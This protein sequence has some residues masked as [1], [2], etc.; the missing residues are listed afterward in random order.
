MPLS[1]AALAHNPVGLA[2][3]ILEKFSTWTNVAYR[4]LND[5]GFGK[6]FSNDALIDNL[7]IYYLSNSIT[8]S[9]RLYAESLSSRHH[10][11][12]LDLV[13]TDVP[14]GCARFKNDLAHELDWQLSAKYH[15]LVHST[16][17][18]DGGHFAALQKPEELYRDFIEFTRKVNLTA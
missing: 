1:G 5:G 3:Y 17:H 16:Y 13:P 7:M 18:K 11:L 9:V 2:A 14:T 4:E 15:N 6:D 10:E 12:R 8:T